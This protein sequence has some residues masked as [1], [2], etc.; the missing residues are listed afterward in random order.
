MPD[1]KPA[2]Q[3]FP[4]APNPSAPEQ[5]AK[6]SEM[7]ASK[8]SPR[9]AK[10]SLSGGIL[11]GLYCGGVGAMAI[12]WGLNMYDMLYDY[13]VLMTLSVSAILYLFATVMYVKRLFNKAF[14]ILIVTGIINFPMGLIPLVVAFVIKRATKWE[15]G[16]EQRQ[17]EVT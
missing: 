14:R 3:I 11:T 2:E 17:E 12:G 1:W 8:S 6:S 15:N 10:Q 16:G 5:G 7:K 4:T 13:L 9:T